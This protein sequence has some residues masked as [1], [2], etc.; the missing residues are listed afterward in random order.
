MSYTNVSDLEISLK[1]IDLNQNEIYHEDL[2]ISGS[3]II[4]IKSK[5]QLN[6]GIY[7]IKIISTEGVIIKK[8]INR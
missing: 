5:M 8:I 6:S 1:L 2:N 7:I 4:P 3:G